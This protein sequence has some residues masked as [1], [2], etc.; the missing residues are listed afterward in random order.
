MIAF[1]VAQQSHAAHFLRDRHATFGGAQDKPSA[2]LK[3]EIKIN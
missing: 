2:E 1:G 3:I